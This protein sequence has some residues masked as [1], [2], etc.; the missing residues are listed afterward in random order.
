[1]IFLTSCCFLRDY[2]SKASGGRGTG[3]VQ[4]NRGSVLDD[5]EQTMSLFKDQ[6]GQGRSNGWRKKEIDQV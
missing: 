2:V 4:K 1:M 5:L 3:V 6:G